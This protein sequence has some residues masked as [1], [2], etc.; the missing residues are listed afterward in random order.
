[1][2]SYIFRTLCY[3]RHQRKR[4][5]HSQMKRHY[6]VFRNY[7]TS[8]SI[9]STLSWPA[10]EEKGE[11]LFLSPGMFRLKYDRAGISQER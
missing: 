6:D 3:L 11:E 8:V 1:M 2:T 9:W 5:Y 10:L 7:V 4:P